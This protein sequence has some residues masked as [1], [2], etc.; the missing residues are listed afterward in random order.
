MVANFPAFRLVRKSE[1]WRVGK[2]AG[3][4]GASARAERQGRGSHAK[5]NGRKIGHTRK[6]GVGT[7]ASI[8]PP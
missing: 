3:R 1:S 2:L 5:E 8:F 7:P 6:K 4:G